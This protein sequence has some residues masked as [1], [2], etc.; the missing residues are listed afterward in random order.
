MHNIT[1][2]GVLNGWIVNVGCQTV[3]FDDLEIMMKEIQT[4]IKYPETSEKKYMENRKNHSPGLLEA[5][6]GAGGEQAAKSRKNALG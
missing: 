6:Q 4:Y 5:V 3:V 1:I 2:K